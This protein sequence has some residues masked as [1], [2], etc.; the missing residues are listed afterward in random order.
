MKNTFIA[1]LGSLLLA[2]SL[3]AQ[4]TFYLGDTLAFHKIA[5]GEVGIAAASKQPK[6]NLVIPD[7]VTFDGITYAVTSVGYTT[8]GTH[9]GP[10][11]TPA[12]RSHKS[13][14]CTPPQE[15]TR[16]KEDRRNCRRSSLLYRSASPA[17]GPS[18]VSETIRHP[19]PD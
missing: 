11:G 5:E 16:I 12:A 6:G 7:S 4:E 3:P 10:T 13:S 2:G 9:K 1:L 18:S 8:E 17:A 19:R 14:T 15:R